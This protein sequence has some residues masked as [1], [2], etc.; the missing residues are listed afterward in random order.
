M[1]IV[2]YGLGS[3]QS[4]LPYKDIGRRAVISVYK[5]GS[6]YRRASLSVGVID[7]SNRQ[8]VVWVNCYPL[9]DIR[10]SIVTV[11]EGQVNIVSSKSTLYDEARS[12]ITFEQVLAKAGSSSSR[13]VSENKIEVILRTSD[14]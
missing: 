1:S 4:G 13:A 7:Q 10:R 6:V 12:R 3:T 14:E 8:S 11:T 2:T 9:I 5:A